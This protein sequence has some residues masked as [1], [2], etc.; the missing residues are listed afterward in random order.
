[1]S[2]IFYVSIQSYAATQVAVNNSQHITT[3]GIINVKDAGAIGDGITDDTKA[4][5][6]AIASLTSDNN[7]VYF[8]E[9][10]Y[11]VTETILLPSNITLEG[12]G[13]GSRLIIGRSFKTGIFSAS[14][15]S[16]ITISKLSFE[17]T[18]RELKKNETAE[19]LIFFEK[20]S[21][22]SINDC[23]LGKTTI[24]IQG[25]GC[26]DMS[27]T[28][29]YVHDIKHREDFS[30]GY[31]M[32]FNLSC[33]NVTVSSNKFKNIGRHSIYMSSGTS[34]AIIKENLV[35]G[36]ESVAIAVYSKSK[37]KVSE[38]IEISNNDIRNV[39]G[40]VSPRGISISVW[41][42]NITVRMNRLNNIQ[43][44]GIAVEGGA[45]EDVE[46][47]PSNIV[48][49]NNN[50]GNCHNA[51]IWVVNASG[52]KVNKNIINAESGIVAGI[53]G[54]LQGSYLKQFSASNNEI[55]YEKYGVNVGGGSRVTELLLGEN[56]FK[57]GSTKTHYKINTEN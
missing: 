46:H 12:A 40:K 1:V 19:R 14:G 21:A 39:S 50:I 9:G 31:G 41:C 2:F 45:L 44:Y 25:Q 29:C 7:K 57:S 6:K 24:A 3:K 11:K 4:I 10:I 52:I 16:N 37:Q 33:S 18:N 35:D 47:N 15:Q 32:L 26:I 5:K 28:N 17:G 30:E 36:C 43:Q 34:N 48:I 55:N 51:G 23:D 27:V 49:E 56:I 42:K 22:I 20:C 13:I 8:P 38:N 53:A 54:K